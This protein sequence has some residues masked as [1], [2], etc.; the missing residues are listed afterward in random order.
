MMPGNTGCRK[1]PASA[2]KTFSRSSRLRAE[3]WWPAPTT[4]SI[5]WSNAS[6]WH[7]MNVV[8]IEHTSKTTQRHAKAVTHTA[9]EKKELVARV[10][11]LELGSGRWLAATTERH[12]HEHRPGQNLEGWSGS[13][14]DGFRFRASRRFLV[15]CS[16]AFRR[17]RL[18]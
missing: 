4:A 8:V 10:N 2:E 7:S 11:D 16:Y 15:G 5:R 1:R 18:E 17:A 14:A 13:G 6:E 12:L 9:I 3:R